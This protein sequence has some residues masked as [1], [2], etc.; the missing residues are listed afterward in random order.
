MLR[1]LCGIEREISDALQF[2]FSELDEF[3]RKAKNGLVLM[4]VNT[5]FQSVVKGLV[6]LIAV[7]IDAYQ[8]KKA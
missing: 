4:G 2:Y 3:G 5:H 1:S 6:L 7:G 8:G